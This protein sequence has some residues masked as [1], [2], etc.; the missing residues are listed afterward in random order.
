M[1]LF[2]NAFVEARREGRGQNA[3][4][5]NCARANSKQPHF[6]RGT[7]STSRSPLIIGTIPSQS[8]RT[9]HRVRKK[10]Q[11]FARR[12]DKAICYS[13]SLV[14]VLE[15]ALISKQALA[16]RQKKRFARHVARMGPPGIRHQQPSKENDPRQRRNDHR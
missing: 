16:N 10:R 3:R 6:R 11:S 7:V 2:L 13:F 15:R 5:H 1:R 14:P 8:R 4:D 12:S 9:S